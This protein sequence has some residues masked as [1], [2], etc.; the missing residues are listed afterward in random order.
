M[1]WRL[2]LSRRRVGPQ[3]L[4][5]QRRSWR[6]NKRCKLFPTI[7]LLVLVASQLWVSSACAQTMT[8]AQIYSKAKPAT[9]RVL[10]MCQM[11]LSVSQA[12]PNLDICLKACRL[13]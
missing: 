11:Q 4:R 1:A 3:F 7:V 13:T 6:P 10:M 2:T 12:R 8:P 9:V 5:V